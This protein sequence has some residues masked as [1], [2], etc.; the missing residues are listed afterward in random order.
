MVNKPLKN[1]G[2]TGG[3]DDNDG[4]EHPIYPLVIKHGKSSDVIVSDFHIE[5]SI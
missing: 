2:L 1:D 5:M 4:E 3:L